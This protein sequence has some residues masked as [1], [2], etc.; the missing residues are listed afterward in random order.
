VTEGA[1]IERGAA[2]KVIAVEGARVVVRKI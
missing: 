1:L 2:V